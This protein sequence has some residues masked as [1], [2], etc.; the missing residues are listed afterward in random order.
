V[1]TSRAVLKGKIAEQLAPLLPDF[2]AKYNPADARFIGSPIDYLIFRNMSKG[3]D[4]DDPIEIV[5][6]DVKTG[7]AG[8]KPIQKKI[9]AAVSGK[10]ISFDVLRVSESVTADI[11]ATENGTRQLQLNVIPM[12]HIPLSYT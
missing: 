4:S 9:E 2:L 8:L 7:N 1:D 12:K 3:D 6:L 11:G 10:R 5:L